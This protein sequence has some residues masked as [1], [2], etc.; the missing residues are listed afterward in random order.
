MN[1][2]MKNLQEAYDMLS[3]IPVQGQNVDVMYSA[4]VKLRVAYKLAEEKNK[5]EEVSENG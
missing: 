2:I 4:R 5:S 1:E 3:T